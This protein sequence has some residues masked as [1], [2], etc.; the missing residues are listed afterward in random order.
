[1]CLEPPQGPGRAR[2]KPWIP[3]T[4]ALLIATG[5]GA[6]FAAGLPRAPEPPLVAEAPAHPAG[7]ELLLRSPISDDGERQA[8]IEAHRPPPVDAGPGTPAA[9]RNRR[10]AQARSAALLEAAGDALGARDAYARAIGL[11]RDDAAAW[12]GLA[13]TRARTGDAAGA[14]AALLAALAF[15]SSRA[16]AY[17][18]LAELYQ[19]EGRRDAVLAL[20]A[21]LELAPD[22]E[23]AAALLARSR[24]RWEPR[25]KLLAPPAAPGLWPDSQ[26]GGG[27]P[28]QLRAA[29]YRLYASLPPEILALIGSDTDASRTRTGIVAGVLLALAV[30]LLPRWLRQRGDLAVSIHYP[31][32]F[33]GTFRVR[34]T[35]QKNRYRPRTPP[36]RAEIRK[37]GTSSRMEHHFVS[38]ETHFRRIP[39]RRYYVVVDGMLE[40]P[41][42]EEVLS[43]VFERKLVRV[44]PRRTVRVEVDLQPSTC[45]V[46]VVV[47]WDGRRPRDA[48]VTARALPRELLD[49]SGDSV[50]LQLPKGLHTLVVGSGDRVVERD[51]TVDSFRPTRVV[52]DI[53]DEKEAIFRGCPPAV[54]PY[55]LGDLETVAR[56]LE[57]DGQPTQAHLLLAR[58]HQGEGR[59]DQAAERFEAAGSMRDA[60]E[61]RAELREF[62]R[63]GAL[64]VGAGDP[65][66]AAAM[67]E[68]VGEWVPAGEAFEAAREFADAIR[69]YREAGDMSKCVDALDR[70][71]D[72]LGAAKMALDNGWRARAIRLLRQVTPETPHFPEACALLADAFER[73]GHWDLAAQKLEEHIAVSG[74]SAS[75]GDLQSRLADLLDQAG[76]TERALQLLQDLRRREP[77]FPNVA[78][79]IEMLRKKRSAMHSLVDPKPSPGAGLGA[80]VDHATTTFLSDYRYEIIEEMGRGGM[81]VVF[82][83]RDRRLARIVALKR[84]PENLKNYPRAVQLFLREAQATARLNHRNIVTVYDADQEDGTFF[85]TM[86][87]L[88]GQPLHWVL[89]ERGQLAPE[90]VARLGVQMAQGLHHAHQHKVVHR[91]IKTANFFLTTDEVIKIMDFGLAKT[92]EEVRRAETGIGGTPFYMA[93][94]QVAG[95]DVDH[96]ADLYSLGATFFELVTGRVPFPDGDVTYHHRHTP[97]PDP[98]TRLD[99]VPDA[100]ADLILHLLEKDVDA[101]VASAAEVEERLSTLL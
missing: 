82:K 96:R 3:W 16:D 99:G 26:D 50:R 66:R 27:L 38:R 62:S 10:D 31:V 21:A 43:D 67:F 12:R 58:K 52:I 100:L 76:H 87:L 73:E 91:D 5:G 20:D 39:A 24:V 88:E 61:L 55:L 69:C 6:G 71:G 95:D 77:T 2:W 11:G 29:A 41:E 65:L 75:A 33:R 92:L 56:A 59:L 48:M 51:I 74:P 53:A 37:G 7:F 1:M 101:R 97:A 44:R 86:E 19:S 49:A 32:E 13:R 4:A 54:E 81:G 40:D 93:P 23:R 64:F 89:R 47:R 80:V 60:A 83:A 79:R 28:D 18:E 68:S 78:T 36:P 42:S 17:L 34:L 72:S 25:T 14:E 85:I 45:P 90:E 63:A 9:L 84:L 35:N 70:S 30:L 98:R 57:R 22:S 15:E 46:D 8:R 94:E